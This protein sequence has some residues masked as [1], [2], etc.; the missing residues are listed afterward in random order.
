MNDPSPE[1]LDLLTAAARHRAG[2]A[3][4][5]KVAA[6]VCRTART[7][8]AW[9]RLYPRAWRRLYRQADQL[10]MQDAPVVPLWYDKVIHLV[11]P[12]VQDFHPN[13]LNLLEL[14]R[15]QLNH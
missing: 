3:S 12:W 1:L 11:Q 8:R 13:A 5:D 15:V 9:P 2:G 7:C 10:V 14:R 6:E 4:W